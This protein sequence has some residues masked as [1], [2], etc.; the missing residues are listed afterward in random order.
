[1]SGTPGSCDSSVFSLLRNWYIG[2]CNGWKCL[3]FNDWYVCKHSS[4][5]IPLSTYFFVNI[6]SSGQL[7][8]LKGDENSINFWFAFFWTIFV[9]L[10]DI[11][12][13][14]ESCVFSPFIYLLGSLLVHL[15]FNFPSV[16][17]FGV[18]IFCQ[19][20]SCQRFFSHSAGCLFTWLMISFAV[21]ML[22]SLLQ[23]HLS[24]F[25]IITEATKVLVCKSLPNFISKNI[26]L[27]FEIIILHVTQISFTYLKF[28]LK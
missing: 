21:Q 20:N 23:P 28:F 7:L 15:V 17:M 3:Y 10:L 19:T 6:F 11:C 12:T 9:L 8:W 2:V 14:F 25:A 4:S 24:I 5:S 26:F 22:F 13:S 27:C 16:Y 1:M 18:L